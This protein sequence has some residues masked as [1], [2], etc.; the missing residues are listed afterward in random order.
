MESVDLQIKQSRIKLEENNSS[1]IYLENLSNELFYEIFDYLDSCDVYK[2]FSNLN[3]RFQN[4][5]FHSSFPLK[6]NFCTKSKSI[7]EDYCRHLIIPNTHRILSFDLRSELIIDQ[8]VKCCT[9]NSS[10]NRLES[11]I[12]HGLTDRQLLTMLFYLNSLPCLFSLTIDMEEDYYYNLG[13]IYRLIFSLSKLK[14]NKMSLFGYEELFIEMPI[15]IN[16]RFSTIEYLIIDYSCTMNQLDSLL[17]HTP[18]LCRLRCERLVESDENVEKYQS[19][20]LSYLTYISIGECQVEFDDFEMFFK[21]ISFQLEVLHISVSWNMSYLDANRWEQLMKKYMPYLKNF[22]FTYDQYIDDM[23]K[24]NP[25]HEFLNRFTSSFWLEQKWFCELKID[26]RE[27][28]FVIQP[29]RKEWFNFYEYMENDYIFNQK[30]IYNCFIQMTVEDYILTERFRLNIDK[31]KPAFIAIRF[32]HLNINNNNMSISMLIEILRLLPNLESLKI[33]SLSMLQSEFLSVED[34]KKYLLV[35]IINKITKV[36]LDK[37]T[38]KT[39]IQFLI[40]LCPRMQYF[41]VD[42]MSNTDLKKFMTFI[43]INQMTHIPNLR[44]LSLNVPNANENM[45]KNIAMTIELETIISNYKI[46]RIGNKF[47]LHWKLMQ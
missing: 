23:L 44:F 13:D 9:I 26:R 18:R 45:I 6:I 32:T 34:T 17:R 21:E 38:E 19:T 24:T 16:E 14:Y 36:K 20:T 33:S 40:N 31:L 11:I 28:V 37:V 22:H 42:C 43:L 35:S 2:A 46:Q 4:L 41:E 5:I 29:Q 10:F 47:F 30:K 39:Q 3:I 15:I 8:F 27:M 25:G 12:L 7:I 1:K